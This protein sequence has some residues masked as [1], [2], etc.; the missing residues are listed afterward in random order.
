MRSSVE[1]SINDVV[2]F[3][4]IGMMQ[5]NWYVVHLAGVGIRVKEASD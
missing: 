4:E 3:S 1:R 5:L 2:G